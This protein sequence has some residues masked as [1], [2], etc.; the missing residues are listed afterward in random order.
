MVVFTETLG[1]VS[2]EHSDNIKEVVV[3]SLGQ[4]YKH[5]SAEPE[6]V[7]W[8]MRRVSWE[9]MGGGEEREWGARGGGIKEDHGCNPQFVEVAKK[10][11]TL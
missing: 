10:I 8:R 1:I 7:G 6:L 11:L 5:E 4:S 9:G 3:L 2:H